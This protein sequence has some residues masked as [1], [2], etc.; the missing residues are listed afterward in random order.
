MGRPTPAG[1]LGEHAKPS[2]TSA[3]KPAGA[4]SNQ[5]PL[6][7]FHVPLAALQG[8]AAGCRSVPAPCACLSRWAGSGGSAH[9]AGSHGPAR[10]R[11]LWGFDMWV[12]TQVWVGVWDR[13]RM[14][15]KSPATPPAFRPPNTGLQAVHAQGSVHLITPASTPSKHSP[16]ARS[17]GRAGRADSPPKRR[18]PTPPSRAGAPRTLRR[19]GAG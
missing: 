11:Q 19:P 10:E 14:T 18:R 15:C 13:A 2:A 16:A 4:A 5:P 7:V 1:D 17:S 3:H 12:L 8:P 9:A 6:P